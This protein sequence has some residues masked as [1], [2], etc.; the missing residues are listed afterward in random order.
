MQY[1][2]ILNDLGQ[3]VYV[4]KKQS[5]Q[6]FCCKL[7]GKLKTMIDVG[8][9]YFKIYYFSSFFRRKLQDCMTKC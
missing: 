2:P 7:L 5:L 8:N 6:L 3:I 1:V 4:F 9:L